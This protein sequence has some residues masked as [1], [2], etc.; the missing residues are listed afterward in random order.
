M[1][2]GVCDAGLTALAGLTGLTSLNLDSRKFGDAG[3]AA[4]A[5]LTGLR[6]LD[7]YSAHV[8]SA[9]CSALR[10]AGAARAFV[11]PRLAL[12]APQA[13][14]ALVADGALSLPLGNS[15][16]L[17][18]RA[19]RPCPR[20]CQHAGVQRGGAGRTA[21]PGYEADAPSRTVA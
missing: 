4:L 20:V 18:G 12:V 10:R 16:L 21:G 3:L 9:G 6:R 13:A 19:C 11:A 1:R 7:L 5:P 17:R 15:A 2:G 14:S 8:T